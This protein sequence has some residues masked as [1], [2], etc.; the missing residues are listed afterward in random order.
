MTRTLMLGA[1]SVLL[2][3]AVIRDPGGA[4]QSAVQGLAVWWTI[5]FPGLLPF[6]VLSELLLAFGLIHGLGALL[7]PLMRR[8]LRLPGAAGWALAVGWTAGFPA[9]AEAAASL[10]AKGVLTRR[11]G[12]RLLAAAHMPSPMLMIVVIGAGFL[13]RPEL[14]LLIAA[15]VWSS[16][17]LLAVAEALL[18][19]RSDKAARGLRGGA[20]A[21][22][23]DGG[24]SGNAE[25][26]RAGGLPGGSGARSAVGQDREAG[27]PA[28]SGG[29]P[30]AWPASAAGSPL[31]RAAYAMAEAQ[32]RDGRSFGQALGEAVASGVQ[33]LMAAGGFMI[34]G[35]VLAGIAGRLPGAGPLLD[36]PGQYEAH[37]GAYAAG[38]WLASLGAPLTAAAIAAVLGWSGWS[39]LLQAGSAAAAAGLAFR[40]FL[41]ARLAHAALAFGAALALWRPLGWLLPQRSAPGLAGAPGDAAGAAAGQAAWRAADM[42]PLWPLVPAAALALLLAVGALAA[43]SAA[44]GRR[45]AR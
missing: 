6:L 42:P 22:S 16:A 33:K 25:A 12:Q 15:A 27:A 36:F 3:A 24:T 20:E 26:L 13:K 8:L 23:P 1:L 4:F 21:A 7:E 10:T 34:A 31:D 40:P 5:V 43:L 11:Q 18:D 2:V 9:G 32:R 17:L 35:S 30:P 29:P 44:A 39:A 14:G 19:R 28:S 38:G 37:L 41:A 45:A